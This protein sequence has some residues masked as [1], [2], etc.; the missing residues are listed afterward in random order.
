MR[1]YDIER[2]QI[3]WIRPSQYRG[4]GENT[5]KG[6]RPG[7][8][9]SNDDIN[10]HGYNYEIVYL[11]THPKRDENTNV[12][13]RSSRAVSTAL[14]GQVQTISQEQID[15]FIGVCTPEEMAAIDRAI[16]ISLALD[17][18][19]E[20]WS[21]T[22]EPDVDDEAEFDDIELEKLYNENQ[23]LNIDNVRLQKDLIKA[24]AEAE[25]M[26]KLYNELLETAIGRR[27]TIPTGGTFP[28]VT[29]PR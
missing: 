29:L 22:A 26:R 19:D 14:C 5:I 10:S 24:R 21:T 18:P 23:Q 28:N 17:E 20:S 15:K 2:G 13:I 8:I 4:N 9:V 11:T 6:I 3:W 25:T 16:M 1:N 27:P 7:V 12:T